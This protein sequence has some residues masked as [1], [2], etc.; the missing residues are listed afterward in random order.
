MICKTFLTG[1][2]RVWYPTD[3]QNF[4]GTTFRQLISHGNE[5]LFFSPFLH[6]LRMES[7][8][9]ARAGG[10]RGMEVAVLRLVPVREPIRNNNATSANPTVNDTTTP[11]Q[12]SSP[13][14]QEFSLRNRRWTAY[15]MIEHA[16]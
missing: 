3:Y 13:A 16:L 14:W 12:P 11:M 9:H 6:I 7:L 1:F 15:G 10:G 8:G 5:V 4:E 2:D